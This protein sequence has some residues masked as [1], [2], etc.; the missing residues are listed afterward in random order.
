MILRVEGPV[1]ESV[2][3]AF[4]TE[5]AK[6]REDAGRPSVDAMMREAGLLGRPVPR[7]TMYDLFKG[8]HLPSWAN[9]ETV[10]AVLRTLA[11]SAQRPLPAERT[12]SGRWRMRYVEVRDP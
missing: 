6:L 4:A 10:L 1:G 7:A 8:E 9:V 3:S 12:D 5:L 2:L 11:R